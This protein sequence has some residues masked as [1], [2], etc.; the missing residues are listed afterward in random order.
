MGRV[1]EARLA[2]G[3]TEWSAV[4]ETLIDFIARG[5]S[6]DGWT[7][8]RRMR[9]WLREPALHAHYLQHVVSAEQTVLS[10]LCRHR[11]TTPETDDLAQLMAVSSVGAYRAAL[12]THRGTRAGA[13]LA[14][15]L[16]QTLG[17]LGNGLGSAGPPP[18][19]AP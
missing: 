11:R 6:T 8:V 16:R 14:G 1:L 5:D 15:H 9:L 2:S 7:A 4:A 12:L 19:A 10:A 18:T 13:K 17:T 3:E